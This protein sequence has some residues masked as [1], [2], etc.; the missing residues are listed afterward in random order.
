[1]LS[2]APT[3][4]AMAIWIWMTSGGG[5][6]YVSAQ[7]WIRSVAAASWVVAATASAARRLLTS[8]AG[9]GQAFLLFP[10][11]HGA[12]AAV[13][14]RSDLTPGVQVAGVLRAGRRVWWSL[15]THQQRRMRSIGK[16][17]PILADVTNR[18]KERHRT[19]QVTST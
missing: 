3:R 4:S 13:Q 1:M 19:V 5:S 7:R 15:V 9:A 14:V 8:G 10:A 11:M 12:D 2:E 18:V 17:A 16:S 6:S